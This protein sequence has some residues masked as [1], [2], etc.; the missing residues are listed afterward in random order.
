MAV[1]TAYLMKTQRLGWEEAYAAVRAAKPDAE[2]VSC[3]RSPLAAPRPPVVPSARSPLAPP[4]DEPGFPGAAEALRG[5]GLRRGQQQRPVQ[6][7]PAADAHG[8]VSR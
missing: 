1:V 2:W 8:E 7:V 6:A 4:Q 3:P 5:H